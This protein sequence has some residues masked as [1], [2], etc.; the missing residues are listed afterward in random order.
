M[1]YEARIASW[2]GPLVAS[3]LPPARIVS[4]PPRTRLTIRSRQPLNVS[5][6]LRQLDQMNVD[7]ES[8]R[9][10]WTGLEQSETS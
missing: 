1:K 9:Q 6:L 2:I 8:L 7:V 3:A 10:C 5:K 4:Q